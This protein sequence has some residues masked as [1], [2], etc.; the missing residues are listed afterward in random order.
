LREVP[1]LWIERMHN[2]NQSLAF[3]ITAFLFACTAVQGGPRLSATEVIRIADAEAHLALRRD[4]REFHRAE[5][6]YSASQ[7]TWSIVYTNT[8]GT[9]PSDVIVQISDQTKKA[10]ASFGDVYK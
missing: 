5:A 1:Y 7:R 9:A 6:R 8:A 3:L 10:Q 4:L 2:A